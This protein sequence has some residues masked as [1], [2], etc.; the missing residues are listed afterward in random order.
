MVWWVFRAG[1]P[2]IT[3][4]KVV[5][6]LRVHGCSGRL[7]KYKKIRDNLLFLIVPYLENS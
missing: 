1:I 6:V 7:K 3:L 4:A 2:F 5:A